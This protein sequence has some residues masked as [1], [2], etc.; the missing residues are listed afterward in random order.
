[1]RDLPSFHGGA[2]TGVRASDAVPED[3]VAQAQERPSA[4]R[5]ASAVQMRERDGT[6]SKDDAAL[7]DA[8]VSGMNGLIEAIVAQVFYCGSYGT[9]EQPHVKG[10]LQTLRDGMLRHD[11]YKALRN[12]SGTSDAGMDAARRLL[13]AMVS[14]TNRRLHEGFP[15]VYAYS[16]GR[17]N[18]Y[19]SHDFVQFSFDQQF[20]AMLACV[21]GS[22]DLGARIASVDG[23]GYLQGAAFRS[24]LPHVFSRQM[25]CCEAERGHMQNQALRLIHDFLRPA[26][27]API[28]AKRMIHRTQDYN[29]RP[30][31]L[32]RFPLYFFIASTDVRE[33]CP[34]PAWRWKEESDG[35]GAVSRRHPCY[36]AGDPK[37]LRPQ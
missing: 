23:S 12:E 22:P 36:R 4:E 2:E 32:E 34:H 30:I 16:H 25:F 5:E 20:R 21:V 14:A 27:R 7:R 17:P 1:M 28:R 3:A 37:V 10:L 6:S 18:H 8:W 33:K 15:S 24:L 11:K 19:A 13:H 29:W 35:T 9:K 31:L 26:F